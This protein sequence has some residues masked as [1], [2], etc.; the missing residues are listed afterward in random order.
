MTANSRI[1]WHQV[2]IKL[3]WGSPFWK[4][5]IHVPGGMR[6]LTS[7]YSRSQ[8]INQGRRKQDEGSN[9]Y[10]ICT[11]FCLGLTILLAALHT[12]GLLSFYF[13]MNTL[14]PPVIWKSHHTD[15]G[16]KTYGEG[17]KTK[18]NNPNLNSQHH[19]PP[20]MKL[21]LSMLA[22]KHAI[23]LCGPNARLTEICWVTVS[24]SLKQLIPI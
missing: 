22:V 23:W 5:A 8:P 11:I 1:S 7:P 6:I 3:F 21:A 4:A 14:H 12:P 18:Q 13:H 17:K 9:V 15:I 10:N 16:P 20:R 2:W 19:C 24:N